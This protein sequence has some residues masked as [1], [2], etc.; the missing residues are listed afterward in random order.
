MVSQLNRVALLFGGQ[1]RAQL[2]APSAATVTVAT[3]P[4]PEV[5]R[6]RRPDTDAPQPRLKVWEEVELQATEPTEG[7][8][9]TPAAALK[10]AHSLD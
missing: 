7:V 9:P 2:R 6:Q 10:V 8:E 1:L 5:V 4:A 3:E